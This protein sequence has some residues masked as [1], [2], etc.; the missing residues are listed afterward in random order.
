MLEFKRLRSDRGFLVYVTQVYP[1]MK[2]Y[3]KGFHLSLESWRGGCDEEGWKI[4]REKTREAQA[5]RQMQ[6]K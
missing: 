3:L 5:Q 1:A 6:R 4:K 2:P